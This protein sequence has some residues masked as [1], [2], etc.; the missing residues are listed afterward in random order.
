MT[1]HVTI[2]VLTPS[3]FKPVVR[4]LFD[5][6]PQVGQ[7]VKFDGETKSVTEVSWVQDPE[8]VYRPEVTLR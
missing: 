5:G 3:G 4:L 1:Q 7:S 8:G 6:V 2:R